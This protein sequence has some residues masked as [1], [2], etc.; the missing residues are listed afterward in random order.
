MPKLKNYF[1]FIPTFTSEFS[2]FL[3]GRHSL[4]HEPEL[5]FFILDSSHL[6]AALPKCL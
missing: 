3:K 4:S 5:S 1:S 2:L 6:L